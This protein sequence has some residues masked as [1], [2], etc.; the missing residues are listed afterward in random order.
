MPL[1]LAVHQGRPITARLIATEA[2]DGQRL[3]IQLDPAD[4]GRVEVALRL[5]HAGTAAALFTVDR[6]ETLLLLQRDAR[7]VAEVLSA[8]GFTVDSGSVGFTL[9]DGNGEDAGSHQPPP[10][11]SAP[12]GLPD[13]PGTVEAVRSIWTRHG[14]LDL[15]V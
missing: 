3:K 6:P 13:E 14:L 8:A 11:S 12:R 4:L 9:R 2:G 5:D 15:H 7:A 10:G 1:G